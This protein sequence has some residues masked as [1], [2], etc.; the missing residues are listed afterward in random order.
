MRIVNKL[1]RLRV[2]DSS[3]VDGLSH[4]MSPVYFFITYCLYHT[5]GHGESR[6][7]FISRI[8][9]LS[10]FSLSHGLSRM[11]TDV[12][13]YHELSNLRIHDKIYKS[14]ILCG[15]PCEEKFD[16]SIIRDKNNPCEENNLIS[17]V[18]SLRVTAAL[19]PGTPTVQ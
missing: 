8:Y 1:T 6:I 19:S 5:D 9:E 14:V 13:L 18:K 7:F 16:N 12:F 2:L 10:I 15:T 17:R 11:T 4:G 3:G